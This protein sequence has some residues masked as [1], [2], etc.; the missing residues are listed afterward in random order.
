MEVSVATTENRI[1]RVLPDPPLRL[2]NGDLN[3]G[4]DNLLHRL[5]LQNND[6]FSE[7]F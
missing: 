1:S 4:F 7:C 2:T 3:T 6:F 5:P